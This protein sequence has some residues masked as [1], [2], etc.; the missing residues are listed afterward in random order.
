M[1]KRLD[2]LVPSARGLGLDTEEVAP[3]E[4]NGDLVRHILEELDKPVTVRNWQTVT[5][6][7][8][9]PAELASHLV[10]LDRDDVLVSPH[11]DSGVH[12]A[13]ARCA[14]TV[15]GRKRL[16]A[17]RDRK[18]FYEKYE[19]AKENAKR[20]GGVPRPWP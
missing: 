9:S 6:R 3:L 15:R 14:L 19:R 7:G 8:Y 18:E 1:H 2:E 10:G 20:A 11:K 13:P 16:R 5:A 4:Y 17:I 12:T